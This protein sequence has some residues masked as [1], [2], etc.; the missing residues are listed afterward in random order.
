[1]SG[2]T[3]RPHRALSEI[4]E[5]LAEDLPRTMH[6]LEAARAAAGGGR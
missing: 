6:L 1:M 2:R 5:R 3:L 4:V